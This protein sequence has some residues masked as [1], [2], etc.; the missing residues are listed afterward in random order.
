MVD[1]GIFVF[2]KDW[3]SGGAKFPKIGSGRFEI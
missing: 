1:G 2:S 3:K